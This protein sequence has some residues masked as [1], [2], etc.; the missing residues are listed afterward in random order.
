MPTSSTTPPDMRR[1]GKNDIPGV[2]SNP[3]E[4]A[5]YQ[6][7]KPPS[8]IVQ[9]C[10]RWLNTRRMTF[11]MASGERHRNPA[12]RSWVGS[13]LSSEIEPIQEVLPSDE[14]MK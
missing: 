9:T 1:N 10:S 11:G 13:R 6:I 4:P 8:P 7:S 3:D 5:S 2:V 14:K 12:R